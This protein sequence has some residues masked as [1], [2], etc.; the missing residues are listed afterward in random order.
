MAGR[1]CLIHAVVL[2]GFFS[3]F[4]AIAEWLPA[5]GKV[6]HF[7]IYLGTGFVAVNTLW[8]FFFA[9]AQA[10][11]LEMES[12]ARKKYEEA[13][14]SNQALHD[15][16]V[17]TISEG[18]V[19][20]TA[21]GEI[22]K[23]NSAAE[24]IQG[25]SAAQMIGRTATDQQGGAIYED[26]R[27]FPGELHPAMVSLRTG[28][29]MSN[30][31]MGIC[32]PDGTPVWISVNSKPVTATE[33]GKPHA[34]I[35]TFQDIT[36]RK[37]AEEALQS[38]LARLV[39]QEMGLIA[40]NKKEYL[41]D[42]DLLTSLRRITE[43]A[44]R[45]LGVARVSVWRFN[46][47]RS[48]IRCVDLYELDAGR[49]SAGL[50][51][52]VADY[53]AYFQSLAERDVIV[54]DDACRD[55]ATS[56]FAENYLK[57]LG[58]TSMMDAP[59][60]VKGMLDGVVCHEHVGPLRRWT[61]DE[62]AFAVAMATAT[63]LALEEWERKRVES[64]FRQS[65]QAYAALV[66]TVDGIVWEADAE[67]FRFLFVSQ[68]A[69][70]LLG[71]P[72]EAWLN[73]PNFWRDHLHPE[74][75]DWAVS[76]C[77]ESV[78]LGEDHD[79]CYRM[80]AADGRVVWLHDLVS[81]TTQSNGGLVLRGIMVDITE[82]K[83]GEEALKLFRAL[84]DRANDVIEVIDP[85]TGHFLDVN[86]KACQSHGYSR[87]EYLSLSL[88]EIEVKLNVTD[89][90]AWRNH[91]EDV[92]QTGFKII[93]GEHRRKDGSTFPVEINVT[94]IH[95]NRDY[96][97]AVVRDITERRVAEQ[98]LAEE[99]ARFKLIFDT[100]PIGIAFHTVHPDGTFT[101][102]INNAHLRICGLTRDQHDEPDVYKRISHP[103]DMV[104]QR[105]FMSRVMAGQIKQFSLEKRYLHPDG[106]IVWVKFSY[107]RETYPD[108]TSEELTTVVDITDRRQAETALRDSEQR[109]RQV[110][111][112]IDEVFWLTNT[113]K[114]EMI[115]IS[116]AY[117]RIWER[118]CESLYA[119]PLSWVE[120]IQDE[121][122]QRVADA[123][124]TLQV[125]GEYD[126]EYRIR[127]PD[128]TVRWIHDR[129][130][131]IRDTSGVVCRIAGIA[132]DI[133]SRRQLEE[134]L[135]QSQKMEAI[136]QL[137]G[138]VAHDFNNI[139]AVIELQT[140][141]LQTEPDLPDRHRDMA[142]EIK[143]A[144]QRA[145]NLTRQLLLFGRKQA[146]QLR[147]IDLNETVTDIA[148]MLQRL[149]GE[150]VQ[151]QF[152]F[153][154]RRLLIHADA[155]MMDQIL[156]NL[157][158]NA[159][160]AMSGG[161]RV[162]IET[163]EAE[164]DQSD[165]TPGSK[166]RPGSFVCVSVTDTG[167]GIPPEILP[168][169][170]EPFFSTKDVGK[171]TGLGLATVFGI[172]QQHHGWITVHSKVGQGTTFQIYF[173]RLTRTGAKTGVRSSLGQIAG[174][175]ETILVVEDDPSLR[176]AMRTVLSRLGY[177]ILEAS[178]GVAGWEIWSQNRGEIH[179]MITDMVMPGGMS[180]RELAEKILS[181][182]PE[183][184]VVYVSG[185]SP[186]TASKSFR[187][188]EGVN[189]LTKPFEA[190]KLAQTVRNCLDG[191]AI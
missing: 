152:I 27:P 163:S 120:A 65:Q 2:T 5:A 62:R 26:G 179:L 148:R 11:K 30:V 136:G 89:P 106:R 55:Q 110:T 166:I 102:N 186:E 151:M 191:T 154:P 127:R 137:A 115:Y 97:V 71:Y 146:L 188:E 104:V 176:T 68:M 24:K 122:R 56:E 140:A 88:S 183:L 81:V 22:I 108:G 105:Q 111:E 85:V 139:L 107:Q 61:S 9:R 79:F 173:P 109:F 83:R 124:L 36:E 153:C 133:T 116:P 165:L 53:P 178:T 74:D 112:N 150:A 57:P 34:V 158:V 29:P 38:S 132:E 42:G 86:E 167:S 37:Q 169:I 50:E 174:G 14:R 94:Y 12:A 157:T 78:K 184:K 43:V 18:V 25:L 125:K 59:I 187:M 90:V 175:S 84:I 138:G 118:T 119:S 164:F 51:L 126:L 10:L 172:V 82:S 155:G 45:T 93:E 135:R 168:R 143:T 117:E 177:R 144:A 58:I 77:V 159:R 76:Y 19:F 113:A 131:P 180:G 28:Q 101:R 149:L 17:T 23:V 171:G 87:E 60:Q 91:V 75:R 3:L 63:A 170:F 134:Q 54:A 39:R 98:R 189:F 100:I 95:L 182:D 128:G 130:F 141:L 48:A 190:R 69:E 185:Y 129:A 41:R 46:E 103:D 64:A 96:L 20:Q 181:Q 1:V 16:V 49:H 99:Q 15:S 13:L 52:A 40:L 123:A 7:Q 160:D 73:E 67:T 80:I 70:R 44:G 6:N 66:N 147:D 4:V 35:T 142:E 33:G 156:L 31:V 161:G 32:R 8:L 145:A 72:V 92:R 21:S 114:T 121:D 47:D 162:T